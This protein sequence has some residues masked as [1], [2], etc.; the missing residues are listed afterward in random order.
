MDPRARLRL[1]ASNF[2]DC[3]YEVVRSGVMGLPS[4]ESTSTHASATSGLGQ[5]AT[6]ELTDWLAKHPGARPNEMSTALGWSRSWT[7]SVLRDAVVDGQVVKRGSGRGV[8]YAVAGADPPAPAPP[9]SLTAAKARILLHLASH[10]RASAGDLATAAGVSRSTLFRVLTL[11]VRLGELERSRNGRFASYRLVQPQVTG[12]PPSSAAD[13]TFDGVVRTVEEHGGGEGP[14]RARGAAGAD[15]GVDVREGMIRLELASHEDI[16]TN[17]GSRDTV[18]TAA[19]ASAAFLPDVDDLM[20]EFELSVID[21]LPP[22]ALGRRFGAIA[23]GLRRLQAD[24]PPADK[25][26]RRVDGLLMRLT[27]AARE[28]RVSGVDALTADASMDWVA[29]EKAARA[30]LR[31]SP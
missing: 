10:P 30:L 31:D 28:R 5:R 4:R 14:E 15:T 20:N 12:S 9:T 22:A 23:A 24:L 16:A 3:L 29:A 21:D 18:E 8:S 27:S 17:P 11:A 1:A 7:T 13:P 26:R 6:D 2:V 25:L 19:R